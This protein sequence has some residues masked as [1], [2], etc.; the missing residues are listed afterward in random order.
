MSRLTHVSKIQKL[1][2]LTCFPLEFKRM[3]FHRF[4]YGENLV[5]KCGNLCK[6]MQIANNS[7]IVAYI[8]TFPDISDFDALSFKFLTQFGFLFIYQTWLTYPRFVY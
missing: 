6:N 7:C 2:T 4:A 3:V 8:L 5:K 1:F